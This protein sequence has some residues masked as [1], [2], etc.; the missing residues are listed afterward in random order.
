M[1]KIILFLLLLMVACAPSAPT[2]KDTDTS[3]P[4]EPQ[5]VAKEQVD[6]P[7]VQQ[8]PPKTVAPPADVAGTPLEPT[9]SVAEPYSRLGC[10]KLLSAEEFAD[11]CNKTADNLVVT[12]R[13]GTRNCIVNIKDR[14]NDRLTAGIALTGYSDSGTAKIEFDR[15]LVVM[16]VGA[17]D[18]V[19]ERAYV[20]PVKLV[21]REALEFLRGKFI[22][23]SGTD[24]RLCSKEGL[25]AVS[26]IVDSRLK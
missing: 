11:E 13:I 4:S 9:G 15:R 17:D 3:A 14:E 20:P 2:V 10:E 6:S 7:P 18:S 16:K 24:S 5:V 25:I 26:K 21:N 12:Y 23:E 19:G 22:I 1:K 8:E